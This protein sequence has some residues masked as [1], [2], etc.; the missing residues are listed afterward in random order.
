MLLGVVSIVGRSQTHEIAGDTGL[1]G[2][3][4]PCNVSDARLQLARDIVCVSIQDRTLCPAGSSNVSAKG[5]WPNQVVYYSAVLA[6]LSDRTT[7]LNT[8]T[9]IATVQWLDQTNVST[10]PWWGTWSVFQVSDSMPTTG[11]PRTVHT[12][13]AQLIAPSHTFIL[14]SLLY[15]AGG[16]YRG[17]RRTKGD[18]DVD[19]IRPH[20]LVS[21]SIYKC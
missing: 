13:T 18:L 6:V 16:A 5:D 17:V 2:G 15:C 10:S 21:S 1:R 20:W 7:C 14:S 3:G 12:S 4:A 19:G 8:P 11:H 9:A